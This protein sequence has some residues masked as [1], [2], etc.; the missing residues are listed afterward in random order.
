MRISFRILLVLALAGCSDRG[1]V[2]EDRVHVLYRGQRLLDEGAP[3]TV[4]DVAVGYVERIAKSANLQRATLRLRSAKELRG[5]SRFEPSGAS[6]PIGFVVRLGGGEPLFDGAEVEADPKYALR[7]TYAAMAAKSPHGV[8]LPSGVHVPF[9]AGLTAESKAE[10][11]RAK[12]ENRMIERALRMREFE[13][14]R[15]SD[16]PAPLMDRYLQLQARLQDLNEVQALEMLSSDGAALLQSLEETRRDA[17]AQG[18]HKAAQAA[19]QL[20][21]RVKQGQRRLAREVKR[22]ERV[23]PRKTRERYVPP[24]FR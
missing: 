19:K 14:A 16:V 8:T 23:G 12:K 3:V 2:S 17:V 15:F 5:G 1:C 20:A 18:N 9:P 4:D 10:E 6:K 21:E 13:K 11:R 24:E 22:D 7:E